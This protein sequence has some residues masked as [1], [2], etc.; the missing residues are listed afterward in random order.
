VLSDEK[1]MSD[2]IAGVVVLFN[3]QK[4]VLQNIQTYL[5]DVEI[6]YIIDNSPNACHDVVEQI[7]R[8]DK[9][10][11]I[12]RNK[13]IGIA[14]ALNI[15]AQK[16][17]HEGFDYLLTMDQDSVA[18]DGMI[19]RMLL[20]STNIESIGLITPFHQDRNAPK[21]PP[22]QD[23]ESVLIAMTSGNLLNLTA[24]KKVGEFME[25][26][27]IDFVDTEYC[28]RL[29]TH[30]FSVI[31]ANRATLSHSLGHFTSR[32][33]FGLTVYPYNHSPLRLY[34]Q[35]R[36]RFFLRRLYRNKYPEYF[37]YDMKLFL[38]GIIKIVLYE[39]YP[40]RKLI[41]ICRGFLAFWRDDFSTISM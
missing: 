15:A 12:T 28:L 22:K 41:M 36:N 21:M 30:G 40:L 35:T 33:F 3:P 11:Y 23:V 16:A 9:V 24:Y 14:A 38:G 39:Q 27:F 32:R 37:R 20:C 4:S 34:Y 8:F 18:S 25:K 2:R 19:H 31:R 17:I 26:L 29:Q 5:S 10:K 1:Y 6:L 13:N 7:I